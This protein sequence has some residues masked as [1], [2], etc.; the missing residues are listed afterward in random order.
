MIDYKVEAYLTFGTH[1]TIDDFTFNFDYSKKN[2]ENFSNNFPGFEVDDKF[3]EK[4]E[5]F[6][7]INKG[8]KYKD[9][10]QCIS[11]KFKFGAFCNYFNINLEQYEKM[12]KEHINLYPFPL[13]CKISI[14]DGKEKIKGEFYS[15]ILHGDIFVLVFPENDKFFIKYTNQFCCEFKLIKDLSDSEKIWLEE[16]KKDYENGYFFVGGF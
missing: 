1:L 13:I 14:D 12:E 11:F 7:I 4:Y 10:P 6:F 16:Y 3:K 15:R 9:V 2:I 5:S 8:K